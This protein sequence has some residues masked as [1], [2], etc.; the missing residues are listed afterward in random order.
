MNHEKTK[1]QTAVEAVRKQA[2]AECRIALDRAASVLGE[3]GIVSTFSMVADHDGPRLKILIDHIVNGSVSMELE[4][5]G[6]E[7]ADRAARLMKA[8]LID[9][10]GLADDYCI[11]YSGKKLK[12]LLE[13]DTPNK[14]RKFKQKL[15]AKILAKA[16]LRNIDG[17]IYEYLETDEE[18]VDDDSDFPG[19]EMAASHLVAEL[20]KFSLTDLKGAAD[21][22]Q[23]KISKLVKNK[24]DDVQLACAIAAKLVEKVGVSDLLDWIDEFNEEL[25]DE[26]EEVA[27]SAPR[28]MSPADQL[29][30]TLKAND[31]KRL[32]ERLGAKVETNRKLKGEPAPTKIQMAEAVC[33]QFR[34][35]QIRDALDALSLPY[36]V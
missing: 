26:D 25:E 7:T 1:I 32:V 14:E 34:K 2:L 9:L 13:S 12:R 21:E 19:N 35:Q 28:A 36:S 22:F 17:W 11:E 16:D 18:D 4:N 23:V 5:I 8:D 30:E 24:V 33:K 15:I 20:S 31:L 10:S 27:T 29:C 6:S 3:M